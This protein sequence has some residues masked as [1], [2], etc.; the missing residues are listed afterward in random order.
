MSYKY[1]RRVFSCF[2]NNFFGW[3]KKRKTFINVSTH[4]KAQPVNAR[5]IQSGI[6][7]VS[8]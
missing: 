8:E 2:L 3:L 7:F 6:L 5:V 1:E 4:W